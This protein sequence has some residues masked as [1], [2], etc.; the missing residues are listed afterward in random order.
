MEIKMSLTSYCQWCRMYQTLP[1]IL[2]C[3]YKEN[4]VVLVYY[5]GNFW[6]TQAV[7]LY[8]SQWPVATRIDMFMPSYRLMMMMIMSMQKH[9]DSYFSINLGWNEHR[10]KIKWVETWIPDRMNI[11]IVL[12]YVFHIVAQWRNSIFK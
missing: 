4:N 11:S 1:E 9:Y 10:N 2:R 12:R 3:I 8:W 5:I 6:Q 7:T